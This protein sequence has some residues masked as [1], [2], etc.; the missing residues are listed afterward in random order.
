[1]VFAATSPSPKSECFISIQIT[2]L[3]LGVN[4]LC[5]KHVLQHPVLTDKHA[6]LSPRIY[7]PQSTSNTGTETCCKFS[8]RVSTYLYHTGLSS[9]SITT[10][11]HSCTQRL[12]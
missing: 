6:S 4:I 10:G 11:F 7:T 5:A 1:M 3:G 2:L 12:N 9:N 8:T